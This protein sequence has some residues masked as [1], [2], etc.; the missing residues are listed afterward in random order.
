V[1]VAVALAAGQ[2][3]L[4]AVIGWLTFGSGPAGSHSAQ[5]SPP[6]NKLAAPP[7]VMP[8]ASMALPPTPA[9]AT[10]H[11]P[12]SRAATPARSIRPGRPPAQPHAP[13][14]TR[15][16]PP[17]EIMAVPDD[18]PTPQPPAAAP[19]PDPAATPAPSGSGEVQPS[20]T[21]GGACDPPGALGITDD[22]VA[23]TCVP[24]PDGRPVWQIN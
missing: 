2:A 8:T 20:A 13:Q 19:E 23:V 21:V 1:R 6:A 11:A 5:P 16:E 9:P 10:T 17:P 4:C 3:L 14:R 24:G 7:L 12:R 22:D 15:T 18:T